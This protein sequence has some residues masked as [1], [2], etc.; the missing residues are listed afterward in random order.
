VVRLSFELG[1]ERKQ[2]LLG[3]PHSAPLS[4]KRDGERKCEGWE[5]ESERHNGALYTFPP[6]PLPTPFSERREEVI[7]NFLNPFPSLSQTNF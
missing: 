5:S 1:P 6:L 2:F 3:S 4:R 7:G